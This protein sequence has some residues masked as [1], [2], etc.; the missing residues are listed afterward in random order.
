MRWR[1]CSI[2]LRLLILLRLP[3]LLWLCIGTLLHPGL[4]RVRHALLH[5]RLSRVNTLLHSWLAWVCT[6]LSRRLSW[7]CAKLLRR[8]VSLLL[9]S[10]TLV[11]IGALRLIGTLRLLSLLRH[12]TLGRIRW[13][14]LYASRLLH[15]RH[16]LSR[17]T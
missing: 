16:L 6:S 11:W 5:T 10:D 14:C 15:S 17:L 2:L 12:G 7:V 4:V 9:R 1:H 8:P 13:C 3:I